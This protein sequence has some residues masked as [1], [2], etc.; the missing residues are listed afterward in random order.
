MSKN[1]SKARIG[2]TLTTDSLLLS[3]LQSLPGASITYTMIASDTGAV[4]ASCTLPASQ[5]VYVSCRSN[6][7][8]PATTLENPT[9]TK[10]EHT[11]PIPTP[12]TG[13]Q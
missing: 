8:K 1:T 4:L 2:I 13:Q 3:P 7:E 6:S 12:T 5:K 10:Q 11:A 9:S